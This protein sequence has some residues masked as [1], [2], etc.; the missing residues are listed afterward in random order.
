MKAAVL[1]LQFCCKP[2]TAAS[3][4]LLYKIRKNRCTVFF[5]AVFRHSFPAY[6]SLMPKNR[7]MYQAAPQQFHSK[8]AKS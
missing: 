1:L 5:Q 3:Q 2:Y 7:P 6:L 4:N 8:T